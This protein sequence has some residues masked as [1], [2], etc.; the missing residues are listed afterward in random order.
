MKKALRLKLFAATRAFGL[1]TFRLP[2][3]ISKRDCQS[4]VCL[5]ED[6]FVRQHGCAVQSC[7]QSYFLKWHK[8]KFLHTIQMTVF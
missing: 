2:A 3:K 5:S 1:K 7:S 4:F 8:K 6:V